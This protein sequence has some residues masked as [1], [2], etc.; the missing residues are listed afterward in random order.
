LRATEGERPSD[1]IHRSALTRHAATVSTESIASPSTSA[2]QAPAACSRCGAPLAE[3][4]RY[5]LQCGERRVA[6]SSFL[7]GE[8]SAAG[9][10]ATPAG[11]PQP[12]GPVVRAQE[13]GSPNNTLLVIAGVGVLLLA[14]GVGVLIGRS[15]APKQTAAPAEVV[16]VGAAPGALAS[17]SA[18]ESFSDDWPAGKTAYTVQ[19][20]TLPEA[21]T[22]VVA[23]T[24][25]KTAAG[26]K[27]ASAVGALKSADFSSLTAGS[28]IIYSGEYKNRAEAEKALKGLTKS[29][30][31]ATV[32]RVS[33]GGGGSG[34]GAGGGAGA[35]SSGPPAGAGAGAGKPSQPSSLEHPAPAPSL[36]KGKN[37][38]KE[39]AELPNVVETP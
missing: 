36:K 29:F 18:A 24:A 14:M 27:G 3:D 25:A 28:Y 21:G 6:M 32:I 17:T 2:A 5:C 23:V 34:G 7:A 26:G 4:Q 15:M 12:P 1:S 30:P 8:T 33:N 20:Q 10:A 16:T 35:G 38:E 37:Y 11:P 22:T 13:G 9:A 19:L 31:S 39:S